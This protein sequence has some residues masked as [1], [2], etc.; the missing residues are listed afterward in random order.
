LLS[1]KRLLKIYIKI[2]YF[3]DIIKKS[4]LLLTESSHGVLKNVTL[5]RSKGISQKTAISVIVDFADVKDW[6]GN[7]NDIELVPGCGFEVTKTFII[8]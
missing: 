1:Y 3:S 5:S 8:E 4:I 2:G 6:R 7:Y